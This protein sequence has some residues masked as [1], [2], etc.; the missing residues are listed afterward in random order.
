MDLFA[1]CCSSDRRPAPSST[2]TA[3][4][5]IDRSAGAGE[6]VGSS[7]HSSGVA[8]VG[9]VFE[10]NTREGVL[11]VKSL[12]K[13]GPAARAGQ[14]IPG[15]KLVEI[16]GTNVVQKTVKEIAPLILGAPGSS[17]VLGMSGVDGTTK[18]VRLTR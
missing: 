12:A 10:R 14:I 11:L 16:D 4:P 6:D 7:S 9:I 1:W 3:N 5:P 8:G 15:D 17:V 18:A 13:N 2:S